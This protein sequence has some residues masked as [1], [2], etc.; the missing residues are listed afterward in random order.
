MWRHTAIFCWRRSE[1]DLSTQSDCQENYAG[2]K[3]V[4]L[5][6]PNFSSQ[7]ATLLLR[8]P[9]ERNVRQLNIRSIIC[10][11]AIASKRLGLSDYSIGWICA[12]SVELA[13]AAEILDEEHQDLPQNSTDSNNYSFGRIGEHNIILACLPAGQMGTNSAAVVATQM[14]SKGLPGEP[15]T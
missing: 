4:S 9:Y 10:T 8:N 3:L 11:Y 14:K 12:L 7:E 13:A 2:I 15:L 1:P 6:S 5:L